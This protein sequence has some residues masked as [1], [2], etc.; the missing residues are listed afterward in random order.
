MQT[1]HFQT[2]F[3][4]CKL[5]LNVILLVNESDESEEASCLNKEISVGMPKF[6]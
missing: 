4:A 5:K 3:C 2:R 1:T 6:V